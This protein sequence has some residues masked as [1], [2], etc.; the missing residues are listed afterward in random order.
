[1]ERDELQKA[2]AMA[3]PLPSAIPAGEL[4]I[5]YSKLREAAANPQAAR[6][7]LAAMEKAYGLNKCELALIRDAVEYELDYFRLG[8]DSQ[9]A[10]PPDEPMLKHYAQMLSQSLTSSF[11]RDGKEVFAVTVYTGD[12][13][14][15]AAGVLLKPSKAGSVEVRSASDELILRLDKMDRLLLEK[16]DCGLYVR[17]DAYLYH[18]HCVYIAKRNQRRLWSRSAALRD[19]D[20]IYADIMNEWGNG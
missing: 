8:N 18:D 19:A 16:H 10:K 17:R 5:P 6:V 11:S 7:L 14:M 4:T 12:S 20:T 13:P 2:E 15:L 9:A 3:L 1:V